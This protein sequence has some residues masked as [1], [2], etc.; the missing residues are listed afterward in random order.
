MTRLAIFCFLSLSLLASGCAELRLATWSGIKSVAHRGSDAA[1]DE[2]DANKND[3]IERD[4]LDALVDELLEPV[5]D[6]VLGDE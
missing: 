6:F 3:T 1:F 4:E 5:K 2:A